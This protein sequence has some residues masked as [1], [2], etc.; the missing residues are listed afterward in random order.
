M[1]NI[2]KFSHGK[3]T[4]MTVVVMTMLFSQ[5]DQSSLMVRAEETV[6]EFVAKVLYDTTVTPKVW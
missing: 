2:F 5:N 6:E 1:K 3:F 4:L